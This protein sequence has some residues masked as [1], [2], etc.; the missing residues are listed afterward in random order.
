MTIKSWH[1]MAKRDIVRDMSGTKLGEKVKKCFYTAGFELSS[2]KPNRVV[3][4]L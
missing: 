2:P 1:E 4:L 3:I